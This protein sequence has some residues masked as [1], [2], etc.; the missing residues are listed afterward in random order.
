MADLS[1]SQVFVATFLGSGIGT[2]LFM[3]ALQARKEHN[4]VLRAK[5]ESLYA[6]FDKFA[7]SLRALISCFQR[8]AEHRS[9]LED[10]VTALQA[11]N[12]KLGEPVKHRIEAVS[13]IYFPKIVISWKSYLTLRDKND[14]IMVSLFN[15][16]AK[17][18]DLPPGTLEE[19]NRIEEYRKDIELQTR[20]AI[21]SCAHDIESGFITNLLRGAK[22]KL[23]DLFL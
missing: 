1:F 12:S 4:N 19:I 15:D 11:Y 13:A 10:F 14:L 23:K 7:N 9:S 2:T 22:S 18:S 3:F 6:D 21:L 16:I 17:L 20:N 5:L 8:Y